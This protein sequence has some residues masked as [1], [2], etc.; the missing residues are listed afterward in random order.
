ML[1][2]VA[3]CCSETVMTIRRLV[4]Q[5]RGESGG[6]R[7]EGDRQTGRQGEKRGK[8]KEKARKCHPLPPTP[9][10]ILPPPTI[11]WLANPRI[12]I[13]V[14]LQHT[15]THYNTMKTHCERKR[16]LSHTDRD[17]GNTNTQ[18][19]CQDLQEDSGDPQSDCNTLLV[20]VFSKLYPVAI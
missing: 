5:L 16:A 2:C 7:G 13:T 18:P 12:V 4:N 17:R 14:S 19:C 10:L 3:V 9:P 1:R 20:C 8:R 6:S 15:T 11:N